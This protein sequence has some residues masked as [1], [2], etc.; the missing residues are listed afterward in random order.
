MINSDIIQRIGI[1]R[2][3]TGIL[4]LL[5][6]CRFP[7]WLMKRVVRRYIRAYNINMDEFEYDPARFTSFNTF[8]TRHFKPG[9]RIF[10]EGVASPAEGLITAAGSFSEGQL[11]HVKGSYYPVSALLNQEV[12]FAEGSFATIYLSPADYHRVHAPF[13]CTV[14]RI[15]YRRGKLKT[16]KPGQ[17]G[18]E[19]LLYCENDRVI[20]EGVSEYGRFYMV[21]VGAV[22]VGRIRLAFIDGVRKGCFFDNLQTDLVKG[23]EAGL[24]E[25]GSTVILLFENDTLAKAE[26][27]EGKHVL[28]G[29][30][31][32]QSNRELKSG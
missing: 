9:M 7:A 1:A 26:L 27:L 2:A 6:Y 14:N 21:L 32:V 15:D 19:P 28:L 22:V 20:I 16:V 3:I 30:S 23:E 12:Q 4:G 17:V 25:L 13:D 5:A 10:A 24:F 11:F 8:F 31:L 29:E 18:K